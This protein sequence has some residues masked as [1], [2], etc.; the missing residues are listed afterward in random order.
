MVLWR[1]TRPFRTNTQKRCPFHHRGFESKI[2]SQE[3]PGVTVKFDLGVQ[4]E[5]GQRLTVLPKER[6]SH[7]KHPLS[8][9]QEKTLPMD[10][11]RW[12]IPKSDLLYS[13][14]P[15]M[16]T[17][18][19]VSKNKT[20]NWLCSDHELL[21]AKF[22]LKLKKVGKTT[23]PLRYDL[24]QPISNPLWLYSGSDKYSRD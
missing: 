19:T 22:R 12:S 16:E 2:G 4:N 1:P 5:T 8:T 10:I 23:R 24:Y 11:T 15:K 17:L 14:H 18:Y 7:S 20:R 13:L 21:I 6:T 3:I 9:T